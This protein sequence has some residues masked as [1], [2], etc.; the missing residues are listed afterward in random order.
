MGAQLQSAGCPRAV[1]APVHLEGDAVWLLALPGRGRGVP[2]STP[3]LQAAET[4]A[5]RPRAPRPAHL[6]YFVFWKS[7][8][9]G[10]NIAAVPWAPAPGWAGLGRG[11]LG[12]RWRG[13]A[14]GRPSGA[15]G[16]GRPPG[17]RARAEPELAAP[18]PNPEQMVAGAGRAGALGTRHQASAASPPSCPRPPLGGLGRPLLWGSRRRPRLGW[19]PRGHFPRVPWSTSGLT[20]LKGPDQGW[21]RSRRNLPPRPVWLWGP[22]LSGDIVPQPIH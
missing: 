22:S 17:P 4:G 18:T 13:A 16:G 1:Q 20:V 10:A 21:P 15:G 5:P 8:S 9:L 12:H 11:E 14:G 6:A 19:R 7:S 3:D 2:P